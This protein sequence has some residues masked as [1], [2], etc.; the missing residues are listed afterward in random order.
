MS[1]TQSIIAR[2]EAA[3]SCCLDL[4]TGGSATYEDYENTR[5]DLLSEPLLQPH[6]PEW[7]V[8]CRYGGQFWSLM[9][10]TSSTYQ[11]RREFIWNEFAL[12]IDL[13]EKRGIEPT[14]LSLDEV[15]EKCSSKNVADV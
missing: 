4:A 15:L 11:G 12:L 13:M 9:K 1:D 8:S 2:I 3:Q 14:S 10:E 5:A 7:L 6:L